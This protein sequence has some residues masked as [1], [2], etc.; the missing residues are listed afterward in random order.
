MSAG[1]GS[2]SAIF[3]GMRPWNETSS[4]SRNESGLDSSRS[5]PRVPCGKAQ[6]FS[7]PIDVQ[8]HVFLLVHSSVVGQTSDRDLLAV[9]A[10]VHGGQRH[11]IGRSCFSPAWGRLPLRRA[12]FLRPGH[13]GDPLGELAIGFR[14][15]FQVNRAFEE[16]SVVGAGND[17]RVNL[18]RARK[19][20]NRVSANRLDL[21]TAPGD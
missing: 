19:V 11:S 21:R 13:R 20:L 3:R 17:R 5:L 2:L 15:C 9:D 16:P 4:P 6:L 12:F 8:E 10:C 14:N 7:P 18:V 1:L